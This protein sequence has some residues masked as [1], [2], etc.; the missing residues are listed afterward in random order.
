MPATN[1]AQ[2]FQRLQPLTP[3]DVKI[4]TVILGVTNQ[5]GQRGAIA[6][7][8]LAARAG[9]SER[10]A[11][12]GV[13]RLER[14]ALLRVSRRK[15]TRMLNAVNVYDI[16]LPWLTTFSWRQAWERKRARAQATAQTCKGDASWQ[17][18]EILNQER[19]KTAALREHQAARVALRQ[20]AC[21]H[22]PAEVGAVGDGVKVCRRCFGEV[23]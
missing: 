12:R 3:T 5:W 19:E 7:P 15:K 9:M 4:L 23:P 8:A 11:M 16:V 18:A 22:P 6:Y 13:K 10:H 2:I 1:I 17:H 20:A 21:P 14:L